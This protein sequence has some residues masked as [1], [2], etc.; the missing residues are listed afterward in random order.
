MGQS[1][2]FCDQKRRKTIIII[3]IDWYI[4]EGITNLKMNILLCQFIRSFYYRIQFW[5]KL[6]QYSKQD[7]I[8]IIFKLSFFR[9]ISGNLLGTVTTQK[10][11]KNRFSNRT[12]TLKLKLSR[13]TANCFRDLFR[14]FTLS[15]ASG[16]KS[17]HSFKTL[18]PSRFGQLFLKSHVSFCFLPVNHNWSL[19]LA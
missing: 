5:R 11:R 8:K 17:L 3:I 18:L 14:N 19:V 4:L 16:K 2:G 13:L 15:I 9:I 6:Y 12:S 10:E 7:S 1:G